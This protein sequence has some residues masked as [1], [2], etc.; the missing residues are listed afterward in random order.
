MLFL[1]AACSSLPSL[2]DGAIGSRDDRIKHYLD[3]LQAEQWYPGIQYMV[4]DQNG[5]LFEYATGQA[6]VK[7]APMTLKSPMMLYSASKVITAAAVLRLV[8]QKK[9]MLDDLLVKYLPEIPYRNV[10]V[11]QV[12][13]HTAGIPDPVIGNMYVHSA[14]E[15]KHLDRAAML[16]DVLRKNP[17]LKF[18]PGSDFSYSNLGYILLGELIASISQKSYEQFIQ[19]EIFA[20]LLM[21]ESQ[22]SFV[23]DTFDTDSRGYVKRF[24]VMNAIMSYMI[25]DFTPKIDGDWKTFNEHWYFNY[26]A[27]GG[28]IATAPGISLFL[29]DQLAKESKLF[30]QEQKKEF[31]RIQAPAKSF[32][33]KSTDIALA[34]FVNRNASEWYYFHEGSAFGYV[35]EMRIYPEAGIASIMMVNTTRMP[36]KQMMDMIDGKFK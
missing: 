10:T 1:L 31:Y 5:V 6:E 2:P 34:W 16:R 20:P 35:A 33:I 7:G 27:H 8:D 32:I 21:P 17:R 28:L 9:V 4:L 18:S 30:S 23:F 24:S 36:H 3:K 22:A 26:P 12:L 14:A 29:R 25:D 13:T 19:D 11:R 15:S